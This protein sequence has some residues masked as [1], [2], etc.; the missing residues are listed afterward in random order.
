[1]TLSQVVRVVDVLWTC[2]GRVMWTCCGRLLWARVVGVLR[3]RVEDVFCG[4]VVDVIHSKGPA[5]SGTAQ[6]LMR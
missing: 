6:R 3:T 4:S 1:M 5:C 2:C